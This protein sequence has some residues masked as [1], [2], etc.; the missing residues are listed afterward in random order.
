VYSG[1]TGKEGQVQ[2]GASWADKL[3]RWPADSAVL[4]LGARLCQVGAA[5]LP[6]SYHIECA[7]HFDYRYA[8][9]MPSA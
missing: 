9:E 4:M 8:G 3:R 1:A 2:A 6:E 7:S 5:S